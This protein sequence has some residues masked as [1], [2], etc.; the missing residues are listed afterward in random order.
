MKLRRPPFCTKGE[1]MDFIFRW[2]PSMDKSLAKFFQQVLTKKLAAK[3]DVYCKFNDQKLQAFTSSCFFAGLVSTFFAT[4]VTGYW[5]AWIFTLIFDPLDSTQY[6]ADGPPGPLLFPSWNGC[7][8]LNNV[9]FGIVQWRP[10]QIV[11]CHERVWMLITWWDIES[12]YETFT[13]EYHK[14]IFNKNIQFFFDKIFGL[15]LTTDSRAI[16]HLLCPMWFENFPELIVVRY[17]C[18]SSNPPVVQQRTGQLAS[19]HLPADWA[20]RHKWEYSFKF[21]NY[22]SNL[23]KIFTSITS[24]QQ[25]PSFRNPTNSAY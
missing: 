6:P 10:K 20:Y 2:S 25:Q 16:T 23:F 14:D 21:Q 17:G 4:W 5:V 7:G 19:L 24:S 8:R 11:Q 12:C 15:K 3:E 18:F 22:W 13:K 1:M 9:K